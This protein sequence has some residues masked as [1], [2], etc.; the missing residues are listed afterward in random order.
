MPAN[1]FMPTYDIISYLW[2]NVIHIHV[3][4]LV[5]F[6]ITITINIDYF[7]SRHRQRVLKA[8]ITLKILLKSKKSIENESISFFQHLSAHTFE[9]DMYKILS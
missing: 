1:I 9:E 3:Q 8:A 6:V 7:A 5:S 2:A 4:G